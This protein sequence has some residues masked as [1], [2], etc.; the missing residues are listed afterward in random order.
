MSQRPFLYAP[1]K[2]AGA[3]GEFSALFMQQH[4]YFLLFG[5]QKWSLKWTQALVSNVMF[6]NSL[7]KLSQE[8]FGK[9]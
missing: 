9:F 1:N 2:K 6:K 5:V 8:I 4:N 3:F 7:F